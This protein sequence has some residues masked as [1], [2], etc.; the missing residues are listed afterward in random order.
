MA[1]FPTGLNTHRRVA[2]SSLFFV[3]FNSAGFL[4]GIVEFSDPA[5]GFWVCDYLQ[6][7]INETKNKSKIFLKKNVVGND[8]RE[9][10]GLPFLYYLLEALA[11]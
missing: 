1:L 7:K 3:N 2:F 8:F 5:D 10:F 9:K 4:F 11:K 6:R